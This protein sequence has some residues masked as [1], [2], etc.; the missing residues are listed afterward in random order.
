MED[1]LFGALVV[2][3]KIEI[4]KRC[5]S[6]TLILMDMMIEMNCSKLTRFRHFRQ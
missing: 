3:K 4:N 5:N 1:M 2:N 6:F